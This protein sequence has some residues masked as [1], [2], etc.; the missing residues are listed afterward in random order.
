[1]ARELAAVVALIVVVIHST[2]I[3]L[4]SLAVSRTV[5]LNSQMC[6]LPTLLSV[7]LHGSGGARF[8]FPLSP[9]EWSSKAV[10]L[11]WQ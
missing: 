1:M 4:V 8:C 2:V 10:V 5:Q 3:Q 6:P 9:L 7:R 11:A